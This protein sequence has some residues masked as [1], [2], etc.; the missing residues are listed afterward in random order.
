MA[1][2]IHYQFLHCVICSRVRKH[3]KLALRCDSSATELY[4]L[5]CNLHRL[6]LPV[7][8]KI[9][10]KNCKK[11]HDNCVLKIFRFSVSFLIVGPFNSLNDMG[12]TYVC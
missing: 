9:A 11:V 8:L 2:L 5:S 1:M 4:L 3:Y 6:Y 12:L 7:W 10:I